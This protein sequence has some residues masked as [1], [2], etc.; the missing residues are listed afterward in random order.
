MAKS[1]F[2]VVQEFLSPKACEELIAQ[3]RVNIPNLDKD[4]RP[5][6][7]EKILPPARGQ[8]LLLD[9]LRPL[10]PAIESRYDA[11]YKGTEPFV[12][13][14]F[15]E[16]DKKPA[17][18]AGC[19]NAKFVRRKWVKTKDVDLVGVIWLKDYQETIPLDPKFETYGGKLEFPAYDFSLMPQRGTLVLWPAGPHFIHCISP[20]LVSDLYQIKVT[21][22]ITSKEGGLY[23][24]DPS[25]FPCGKEGFMQ[26][27]F[28]EFM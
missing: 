3:H 21:I 17:Q 4:G 22:S 13:S 24:Y 28:K 27:W 20:V 7:L 23:I 15:P 19:E 10:I 25:K 8:S 9:K 11:V 6:K 14:H 1:P 18:E 26:G 12:F 5:I 16:N 2:L